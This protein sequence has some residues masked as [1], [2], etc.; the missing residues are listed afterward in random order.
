MV[1]VYVPKGARPADAH[2]VGW[3]DGEIAR[4]S[5]TVHFKACSCSVPAEDL[6]PGAWADVK[7]LLGDPGVLGEVRMFVLHA[8][9]SAYM[10]DMWPAPDIGDD[11]PICSLYEMTAEQVQETIGVL[12]RNLCLIGGTYEWVKDVYEASVAREQTDWNGAETE[13]TLLKRALP[14]NAFV[15]SLMSVEVVV[16]CVDD[17]LK[18]PL[19]TQLYIMPSTLIHSSGDMHIGM[20]LF[21]A[22]ALERG[23]VVTQYDGVWVDTPPKPGPDTTHHMSVVSGFK[24]ISGIRTARLAIGAGG[25]SFCNSK[26]RR[27]ANLGRFLGCSASR[28]AF[29]ELDVPRVVF[30]RARHAIPARSELFM[31]YRVQGT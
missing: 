13:G 3:V 5:C 22:R 2:A 15:K 25:L 4:E 17:I 30:A 8:A 26:P 12:L 10:K 19:A 14:D 1:Y 31:W 29:G 24:C 11:D 18:V 28:M 7:G 21:T 6:S 16:S 27:H 23:D 9:D 20:G